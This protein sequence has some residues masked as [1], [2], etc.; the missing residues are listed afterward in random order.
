[1]YDALICG[2]GAGGLSA[3]V[4]LANKGARVLVLE[5]SSRFGGL[6]STI[7]RSGYRF[8]TGAMLV[9]LPN[10]YRRVFSELGLEIDEVLSLLPVDPVKRLRFDD[11]TE[12]SLH[13]SQEETEAS[14]GRISARDAR[15]LRRFWVR[16]GAVGDNLFESMLLSENQSWLDVL[17]WPLVRHGAW[18]A[19][20]MGQVVDAYFEDHRVRA[21]MLHSVIYLGLAPREAWG[22]LAGYAAA[23]LDPGPYYPKGGMGSITAALSQALQERGGEIRLGSGVQRILLE[24]RRAIGVVL[25]DGEEIRAKAVLSNIDAIVTYR[26]LV[27]VDHLP[28]RFVRRLGRYKR[29]IAGMTVKLG[30]R[31]RY[32]LSCLTGLSWPRARMDQIFDEHRHG[33]RLPEKI[34]PQIFCPS[35]SDPDMAPEGAQSITLYEAPVP[36]RIDG[37]GWDAERDGFR[38]RMISAAQEVFLPELES[39]IEFMEALCPTDF[40]RHYHVPE[41]GILGL[42]ISLSQMGAFRPKNRSEVVDGLYLAGQS[43]HPMHGVPSVLASG[44]TAAGLLIREL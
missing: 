31:G 19:R 42:D 15:N 26:D 3:A 18:F 16:L 22:P 14:I 24:G 10:V 23:E 37:A 12:I 7:E 35:I 2:A 25:D 17:S 36:Y 27:G 9:L 38:D 4:S 21:A 20:S 13:L 44:L 34:C 40:Q 1:M 39:R 32:D 28:K 29:N 11:G 30:V 43:A 33:S 8:D 41:G 5:K 6:C